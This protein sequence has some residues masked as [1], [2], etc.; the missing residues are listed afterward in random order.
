MAETVA[1]LDSVGIWVELNNVITWSKIPA[2]KVHCNGGQ[3]C[4]DRKETGENTV[5]RH[6]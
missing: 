6:M 2:F 3:L 4:F 5:K 1:H